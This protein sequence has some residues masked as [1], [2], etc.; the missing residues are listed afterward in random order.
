MRRH[1]IAWTRSGSH[2]SGSLRLYWT[3]L[4]LSLGDRTRSGAGEQAGW[5][6]R[7]LTS[8]D[9]TLIRGDAGPET[10]TASD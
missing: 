10:H 6:I 8:N 3:L 7:L 4:L 9:R 1:Q 5:P 2:T